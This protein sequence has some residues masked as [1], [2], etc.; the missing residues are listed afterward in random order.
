MTRWIKFIFL[1]TLLLTGV[2]AHAQML[3]PERAESLDIWW[4]CNDGFMKK[5]GI[6]A[7]TGSYRQKRSNKP[8][9]NLP[10]KVRIV[11]TKDGQINEFENIR[12]VIGKMDTTY[13]YF[14]Q[15]NSTEE[16]ITI[17]DG[18]G[19]I[20]EVSQQYGDT[21]LTYAFRRKEVDRQVAFQELD[22]ERAI[23]QEKE[24]ILQRLPIYRS[25]QFNELGL[26]YR[27]HVLHYDSLGYLIREDWDYLVTS[28]KIRTHYTYDE[29]GR[30][31]SKEEH[32][33]GALQ[34][35]FQFEYHESG[36][37]KRCTFEKKGKKLWHMDVVYDELGLVDAII[38]VYE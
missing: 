4:L 29:N 16:A 11:F 8:I 13:Q 33:N 27:D 19:Y 26:P 21:T 7:M 24:V 12:S 32:R 25:R 36:E 9:E 38:K 23:Y 10:G 28:K 5:H 20:C 18:I 35:G 14:H 15:E 17:K 3:L 6:K 2:L 30:L 31:A 37:L 22:L 34:H 1:N